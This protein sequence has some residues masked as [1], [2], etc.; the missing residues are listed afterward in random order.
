MHSQTQSKLAVVVTAADCCL[1]RLYMV[2]IWW[3][4]VHRIKSLNMGFFN[5]IVFLPYHSFTVVECGGNQ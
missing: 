1:N 5:F 4:L 2:A 3:I